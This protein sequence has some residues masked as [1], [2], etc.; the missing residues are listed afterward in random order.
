MVP[1]T[2]VL[3][4]KRE[5]RRRIASV[6]LLPLCM[7]FRYLVNLVAECVRQKNDNGLCDLVAI[8]VHPPV[9]AQP[10]Q[11]LI[12]SSQSLLCAEESL[13][14]RMERPVDNLV[15]LVWNLVLRKNLTMSLPYANCDMNVTIE[16]PLFENVGSDVLICGPSSLIETS[17]WHVTPTSDIPTPL[18]AKCQP[19]PV[20]VMCCVI[21]RLVFGKCEHSIDIRCRISPFTPILFWERLFV[22]RGVT[23]F[24]SQEGETEV[25]YVT[26]C[27]HERSISAE[28][29]S[30]MTSDGQGRG[31]LAAGDR[32]LHSRKLGGR[33]RL[34]S[35]KQGRRK[36][37]K[38]C[39]PVNT[40]RTS[41]RPSPPF[42]PLEEGI[43]YAGLGGGRLP[44]DIIWISNQTEEGVSHSSLTALG[45]A[46]FIGYGARFRHQNRCS[47]PLTAILMRARNHKLSETWQFRLVDQYALAEGWM[48]WPRM[49]AVEFIERISKHRSQQLVNLIIISQSCP[50]KLRARCSKGKYLANAASSAVTLGTLLYREPKAGKRRLPRFTIYINSKFF[51]I[52]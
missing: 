18:R 48:E 22:M 40:R 15:N 38:N 24:L 3:D 16:H 49:A 27:C 1:G 43:P 31:K 8:V 9:A 42:P 34:E 2:C 26:L 10:P 47:A 32:V 5:G 19:R 4:G 50:S 44:G 45:S 12:T 6:H 17:C 46:N 29:I 36:T 52:L 33:P 28:V 13:G 51:R 7:E 41:G 39:G 30:A 35:E 25:T 23:P 37:Q 20:D 21:G 14:L 11:S